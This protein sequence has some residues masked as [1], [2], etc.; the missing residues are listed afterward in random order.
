MHVRGRSHGCGGEAWPVSLTKCFENFAVETIEIGKNAKARARVG[1]ACER[2]P[3]VRVQDEIQVK[4]RT[5][6]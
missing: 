6:Y 4:R 2:R 5:K 1:E 3:T